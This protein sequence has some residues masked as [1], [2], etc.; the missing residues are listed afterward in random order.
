MENRIVAFFSCTCVLMLLLSVSLLGC[1]GP[2]TEEKGNGNKQGP[3]MQGVKEESLWSYLERFRNSSEMP[4]VGEVQKRFGD[5]NEY[6]PMELNPSYYSRS[7]LPE[8]EYYRFRPDE[9]QLKSLPV[10]AWRY[11]Y[12]GDQNRWVDVVVRKTEGTIVG[13]TW[14]ENVAPGEETGPPSQ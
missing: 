6:M 14:F 11:Y 13:W 9:N 10:T 2:K 7:G 4:S 12:R 8:N 3:D 5:P 1:G